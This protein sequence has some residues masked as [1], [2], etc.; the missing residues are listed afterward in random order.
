M[1]SWTINDITAHLAATFDRF[2][3]MLARGR[4]GD[5]NRPFE[6]DDVSA[7][8]LRAVEHFEG[9]PLLRLEEEAMRFVRSST[10]AQEIMPQPVRPEADP[11]AYTIRVKLAL[12]PGRTLVAIRMRADNPA[13][14]LEPRN[15]V[16][17]PQ[18]IRSRRR[19]GERRPGSTGRVGDVPY[20]V[21]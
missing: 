9:D 10:D 8:N 7:E 11:A 13:D 17:S 14:G 5:L 1:S 12:V 3:R 6:R 20:P 15:H 18:T 16:R 4:L 21:A 19:R 2:N